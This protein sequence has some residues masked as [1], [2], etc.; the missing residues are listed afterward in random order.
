MYHTSS[1]ND[2]CSLYADRNLINR[3]NVTADVTKAFAS[4]KQMFLLAVHARIIAAAMKELEMKNMNEL[5]KQRGS[6]LSECM[7]GRKQASKK[8]L[9]NRLSSTIINKYTVNTKT[10]TEIVSGVLHER[11]KQE[12]SNVTTLPNG[13]FPCRS[14]GCNKSYLVNKINALIHSKG[15]ALIQDSTQAYLAPYYF[16]LLY[17]ISITM[18][19]SQVH[20]YNDKMIK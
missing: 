12:L 6:S 20:C 18:D 16:L 13:R 9:L 1:A 4:D 5:P 19:F 15:R 2:F 17:P 3:R 14:P 8:V 11:E 7:S 10:A